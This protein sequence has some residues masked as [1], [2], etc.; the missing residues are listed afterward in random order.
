[1]RWF[2]GSGHGQSR[3]ALNSDASLRIV[4]EAIAEVKIDDLKGWTVD[5]RLKNGME[6]LLREMR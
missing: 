3:H 4:E 2:P 1:M 6:G 5:N